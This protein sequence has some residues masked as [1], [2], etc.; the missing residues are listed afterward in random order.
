MNFKNPNWFKFAPTGM[1]KKCKNLSKQDEVGKKFSRQKRIAK[2]LAN[3]GGI[4]FKNENK[5]TCDFVF[6]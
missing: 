1:K 3:L 5:N 6:F 2:C 4:L